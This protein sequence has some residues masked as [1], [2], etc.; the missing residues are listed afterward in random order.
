M[1]DVIRT[2]DSCAECSQMDASTLEALKGSIR[3]WEKIV[4]GTGSNRGVA[5]CP[6]CQKFYDLTGCR[7]TCSG[8]PVQK[9][10]GQHGCMGSPYEDYEVFEGEDGHH[11][12]EMK[13]LAVKELNFLQ[14]LLPP[15]E[16]P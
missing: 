9:A 4:A 8:C 13:K 7:V 16:A 15:G 2:S 3:K 14:S 1:N 6:L 10:T 11:E 12:W 5:N